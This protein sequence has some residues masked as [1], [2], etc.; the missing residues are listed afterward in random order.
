MA[1]TITPEMQAF[2]DQLRLE[3]EQA[4]L[5]REGAESVP[6]NAFTEILIEQ[7]VDE[8]FLAAGR[9][10]HSQKQIL[11]ST[12]RVNGYGLDEEEE[13]LD[14]FITLF[15]ELPTVVLVPREDVQ[16]AVKEAVN[17]FKAA[18]SGKLEDLEE[19]LPEFDMAHH[20]Y[21]SR[22]DIKTLRIFVLTN[23]LVATEKAITPELGTVVGATI[24]KVMVE[25]WDIQRL[26]R[27]RQSG[28]EMEPIEIDFTKMFGAP[29]PCLPLS[30]NPASYKGFL[31]ILTGTVLH[32]LYEEFG[33][34]LLERN[35]RSF[36]QARGKVNKGIQASLIEEPQNF[37][38]YNNGL[39]TVAHKVELTTTPAGPAISKLSGLQI[40]NGGQTTASIHFAASKFEDKVDLSKVYVQAKLSVV[41][42][43]HL[44]YMAPR[45]SRNANSQNKVSDT[46]F[47]ANEPFHQKIE[48]L[49]RQVW[50]PD[51]KTCW[52][53]E[54][55]RGQ[56]PVGRAREYRASDS[57]GKKFDRKF[58]DSQM[59]TKT[60][61]ASSEN[62]WDERPFAVS[63]GGQK[64]FLAF[65]DRHREDHKA[66][67]LGGFTEREFRHLI[68][69]LIL[70]RTTQQVV[71]ELKVPA[72]RANVVTYT[73]SYLAYHA[74]GKVDLERI[75]L[76]Q[77]LPEPL[78][79]TLRSIAVEV[80]KTIR[81]SA[82]DR[83]VTE[84]CKKPECWEAVR[85]IQVSMP[86]DFWPKGAKKVVP[87]T[88]APVAGTAAAPKGALAAQL[89]A[90]GAE[91]VDRRA[92]GDGL[93][94]IG[95][96]T[97]KGIPQLRKDGFVFA[98]SPKGGAATG[99]RP[100]WKL[101]S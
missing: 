28:S 17:Y 60:D 26:Q 6:S 93:W 78:L 68:S 9:V 45:I 21:G 76:E 44:E 69:R 90:I 51:G 71:K 72:Y 32:K 31:V 54:R 96:P 84:W 1:T 14:L 66:D 67:Q 74:R 5:N 59:F 100:G 48:K 24:K 53:Y 56:Y 92:D 85:A 11:K 41:P 87:A 97:L 65:S 63:F 70:F 30:A 57:L 61:L 22:A 47:S 43:V 55:A 34:R 25:T 89:A 50:C 23:N 10:C 88:P 36:L 4:T 75:W 95:G 8:G 40:V 29:L 82:K 91:V 58:P 62:S 99:N 16:Q 46:D 42:D 52:F 35:V 49:S 20:I 38:A 98:F 94:V 83:N 73:V 64:N 101:Q 79:N 7:V 3:V 27:A 33:E 81:K 19:G 80:E 86:R 37:F 13:R 12:A 39:S 18:V 2:R 15:D 77:T